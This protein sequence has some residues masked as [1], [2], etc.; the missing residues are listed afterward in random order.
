MKGNRRKVFG[1]RYM[2]KAAARRGVVLADVPAVSMNLEEF[3]NEGPAGK[4]ERY[5]E[6]GMAL[7]T[8]VR[9]VYQEPATKTMRPRALTAVPGRGLCPGVTLTQRS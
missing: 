5:D 7:R 6:E 9:C 2:R 1:E 4:Q 3:D 8:P